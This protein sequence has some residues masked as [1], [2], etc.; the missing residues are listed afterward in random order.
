VG[1]RRSAA[2]QGEGSRKTSAWNWREVLDA[3]FYVL[4]AG[5]PWRFLPDS[6]PPWRSVFGELRDTGGFE[7]LNHHFVQMDRVRTGREPMPSAAVIDSQSVKAPKAGGSNGYDAGKKING[8]KR[9][10]MVDIDG[11]ALELLIHTADVQDRDGAVPL[12]NCNS[13]ATMRCRTSYADDGDPEG[14]L[15]PRTRAQYFDILPLAVTNDPTRNAGTER[16]NE[17][18]EISTQVKTR[19]VSFLPDCARVL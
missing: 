13:C 10:A 3:I 2:A 7:G 19:Q 1:D 14:C 12:L 11:R 15:A 16:L 5:C 4:R 6:F 8:H 18:Q 9:H 17:D